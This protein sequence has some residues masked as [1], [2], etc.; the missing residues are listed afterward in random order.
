MHP[1]ECLR[2]K[3][4]A[5]T[6][7]G[8]AGLMSK[9]ARRCITPRAAAV[10]WQDLS[11]KFSTLEKESYMIAKAFLLAGLLFPLVA[12]AGPEG[13]RHPVQAQANG[14]NGKGHVSHGNGK[15]YGHI[16]HGNGKGYGHY[17]RGSVPVPEIDGSNLLMG[18]LL[19]AG[20]LSV[21]LRRRT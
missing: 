10:D 19:V 6:G 11:G 2:T 9:P 7:E 16:S 13:S 8:G 14:S 15:G 4:R 5:V 17:K 21:A 3:A 1:S 18:L 12:T 20:I